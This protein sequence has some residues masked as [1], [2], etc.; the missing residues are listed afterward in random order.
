MPRP[1]NHFAT[2]RGLARYPESEIGRAARELVVL[3]QRGHLQ[4]CAAGDGERTF[5]TKAEAHQIDGGPNC[6][7]WQSR[8]SFANHRWSQSARLISA[9][10][11]SD[12]VVSRSLPEQRGPSR[13][14]MRII[15]SDQAAG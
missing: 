15:A 10:G 2:A 11:P 5:G 7:D 9:S 14:S 6:G 8:M 12:H 13:E 3:R 4:Y 1:E